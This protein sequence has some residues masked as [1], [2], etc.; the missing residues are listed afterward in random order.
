LRDELSFGC[1][2]AVVLLEGLEY[3]KQFVLFLNL[4]GWQG[5]DSA[6]V[7]SKQKTLEVQAYYI[8]DYIRRGRR[9]Y[10][11]IYTGCSRSNGPIDS[12]DKLHSKGVVHYVVPG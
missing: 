9:R 10:I 1:D 2:V 12:V 4:V 5:V 8:V 11:S 7:E 3:L 6:D